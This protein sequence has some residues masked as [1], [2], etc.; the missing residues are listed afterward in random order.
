MKT[1]IC[2]HEDRADC[3]VGVKIEILSL[4][5]YAADLP[6]LINTPGAPGSFRD[7]LST[8]KDITQI[9][10]TDEEAV[11]FN[12]KPSILLNIL[13]DGYQNLIWIDSDVIVCGD[14]LSSIAIQADD[15]LVAAE[16]TYFGQNQGGTISTA[17]CALA[18]GRS[19]PS[20]INTCLLR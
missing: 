12:I 15:V 11:G 2:I 8:H 6:I 9:S 20:T 10:Y 14:I 19:L 3:L 4:K 16:E 17:A 7:W 13:H 18:V 5:K 1:A